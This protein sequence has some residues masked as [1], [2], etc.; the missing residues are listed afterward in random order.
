MYTTKQ[1]VFLAV[2][3]ALLGYALLCAGSADYE[4]LTAIN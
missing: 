1:K 4:F 2:F 3:F